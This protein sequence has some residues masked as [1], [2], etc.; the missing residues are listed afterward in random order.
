MLLF[1]DDLV[2]I[3]LYRAYNT[4]VF[5]LSVLETRPIHPLLNL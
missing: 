1:P 2:P 5:N 3:M 4:F